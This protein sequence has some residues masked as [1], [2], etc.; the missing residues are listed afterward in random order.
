MG[1]GTLGSVLGLLHPGKAQPGRRRQREGAQGE[2]KERG[3][4]ALRGQPVY[5]YIPS[6]KG[7]GRQARGHH[8]A[9]M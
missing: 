7:P 4:S 1:G 2:A 6:Q 3:I 8:S 9:R 5:F